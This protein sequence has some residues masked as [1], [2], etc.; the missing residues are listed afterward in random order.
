MYI[1]MKK[2]IT[3]ILA[4]FAVVA[5]QSCGEDDLNPVSVIID[6][7]NEN[8]EFDDWLEENYRIP[9]NIR[10]IYKYEDV[11][12]DLSYD[13]VPAEMSQSI[14]LAKMVKYLW[15]DPYA[16]VGGED[17]LRS[18]APRQFMVI[19]TVG[20]NSNSTYTM[21]T[22]EGGLKITLY[23]GNWL[24]RWF[25]VV[26]DPTTSSGYSVEVDRD[27]I[28]YHY[29]HTIHHEFGHILHQTVDYPTNFN[30]VSSG[31]YSATWN[32]LSDSEAWALGF[33]S[34]YASNSYDDDFVETLSYYVTYSDD[35]WQSILDA[36]GTT[37]ANKITLKLEY[38]KEYML[39]VWNIDIDRLK[40]V[41]TNKFDDIEYYDWVNL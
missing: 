39:D 19:G 4:L 21:G 28:N 15:L 16:Q 17:F 33:I 31:D 7:V 38:V 14:I 40:N 22:A 32:D 34:P 8:N 23:A 24:P 2:L 18:Y 35:E 37:G 26:E 29:L 36:A 41:V 9:Y 11:E 5:I 20:W 6:S 13:L 1:R 27:N 3:Y 30:L 25:Q 10:F 12:S